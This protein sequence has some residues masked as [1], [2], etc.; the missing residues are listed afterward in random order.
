MNGLIGFPPTRK[1]RETLQP[2][3]LYVVAT[4]I[5]NLEDISLRALRVLDGVDIIAA[6]DTRRTGLLLK[7]YGITKPLI[8]Y[9]AHNEQKRSGQIVQ[10]LRENQTVAL[11]SDAGTP[12][13]SD[14]GGVL[15]RQVIDAG[16][17]V[18]VI[19][20]ASAG[21]TALAASGFA[22]DAFAFGGFFPRESKKRKLWIDRFGRFSGAVVF[23]ESPKRLSETLQRLLEAWGD[24]KCCIARELTKQYEEFIRGSLVE[25]VQLLVKIKQMK[26]EVVVVIEKQTSPESESLSREDADK[27][28]MEMLAEGMRKKEVSR[29]LA[30]KTGLPAK[31][32]YQDLLINRD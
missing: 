18:T 17:R 28:G 30:Q 5:G 16:I 15:I 1:A 31:T 22:M 24:G 21:L 9:F 11:V 14:P 13:V 10:M 23:Y 4:P 29:R 27:L 7:A 20:G 19:P 6:E 12:G 3:I 26:G 32:H 25:I 2:G 8:S